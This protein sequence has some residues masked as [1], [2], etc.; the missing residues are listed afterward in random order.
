MPAI[1][2]LLSKLPGSRTL[3]SRLQF[4]YALGDDCKSARLRLRVAGSP[5]ALDQL[6]ESSLFR[7]R[8][9]EYPLST[10]ARDS[11][12][13]PDA[14]ASFPAV[15]QG[16][17]PETRAPCYFLHPCETAAVV[18]E[19]LNSDKAKHSPLEAMQTWFVLVGNV[20]NFTPCERW[21]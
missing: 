18:A 2:L 11:D 7:A 3:L 19:V 20:I 9:S 17:H 13:R 5:V 12:E 15:S 10:L 8:P 4:R 21:R 6:L 1:R 16:E 14:P